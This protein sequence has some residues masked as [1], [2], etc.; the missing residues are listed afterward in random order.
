MLSMSVVTV[1]GS[2]SYALISDQAYSLVSSDYLTKPSCVPES[3]E[4]HKNIP[5]LSIPSL[6]IALL[7][8]VEFVPTLMDVP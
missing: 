2:N 1:I 4:S 7:V 6:Q 5:W 8:T 3:G